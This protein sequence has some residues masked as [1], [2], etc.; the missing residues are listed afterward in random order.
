ML[1]SPNHKIIIIF[2]KFKLQ[3]SHIW[4]KESKSLF[5]QINTLLCKFSVWMRFWLA[6]YETIP[7]DHFWI[8]TEHSSRGRDFS[9]SSITSLHSLSLNA[10]TQKRERS[11]LAHSRW[12]GS[13]AYHLTA[14]Q[15][16]WIRIPADESWGDVLGPRAILL[17]SQFNH[18]N[19]PEGRYQ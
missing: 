14:S 7:E 17:G 10:L 12:V 18:Y 5:I 11:K 2:L 1:S 4:M 3:I 19:K 9:S 6:V 8:P 16:S 13:A 15:I